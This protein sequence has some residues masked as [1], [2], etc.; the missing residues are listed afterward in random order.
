MY[1]SFGEVYLPVEDLF[2]LF[3]KIFGPNLSLSDAYKNHRNFS[4]RRPASFYCRLI[5]ACTF[6]RLACRKTLEDLILF[7][8]VNI[9]R[10]LQYETFLK[11][12]NFFAECSKKGF[13][14]NDPGSHF[15]TLEYL[16]MVFP[17]KMSKTIFWNSMR[18]YT[19]KC[20]GCASPPIPP[21]LS[22]TCQIDVNNSSK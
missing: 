20:G 13:R 18:K 12:H 22:I 17:L 11:I 3:G 19:E 5:L 6:C 4:F 2:P 7:P 1:V 9:S 15:C 14:V 8:D 10:T 16:N 21:L